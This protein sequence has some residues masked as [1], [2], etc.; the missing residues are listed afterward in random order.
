MSSTDTISKS[1]VVAA[2]RRTQILD[3]ARERFTSQG[4]SNTTVDDIARAAR[5]AKGTV[6]LYYKSKDEMLRLIVDTDIE[7][8]RMATVPAIAGAETAESLETRLRDFFERTLSFYERNREFIEHCQ[9]EL[10]PD[11][12]KKTRATLARCYQAQVDAWMQALAE[13]HAR[14]D[15]AVAAVDGAARSI[16]SLARGLAQQRLS[17]WNDE[18]IAQTAA[19]ATELILK[20][21]ATR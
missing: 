2:F 1:D 19:Y 12:R 4:V 15:A 11:V 6:Y 7:A 21:L 20:G 10:S 5:V 18:P 8:L 16:V 14:G 13:A 3:A 9:L 17:G